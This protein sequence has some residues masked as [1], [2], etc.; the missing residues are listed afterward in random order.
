MPISVVNPPSNQSKVN[1][2]MVVPI[3][4]VAKFANYIH[5]RSYWEPASFYCS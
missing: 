4:Y 1:I 5:Q 2:H 3:F